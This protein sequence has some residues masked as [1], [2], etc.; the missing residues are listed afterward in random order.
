MK[1]RQHNDDA[2]Q[3]PNLLPHLLAVEDPAKVVFPVPQNP[4]DIPQNPYRGLGSHS[5]VRHPVVQDAI[6]R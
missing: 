2:Q 5:I 4:V 1:T 3:K 6:P